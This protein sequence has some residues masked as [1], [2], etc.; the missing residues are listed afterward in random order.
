MLQLARGWLHHLTA[1]ETALQ[2]SGTHNS[3]WRR[4]L[5]REGQTD[6]PIVKGRFLVELS[7]PVPAGWPEPLL[8]ECVVAWRPSATQQQPIKKSTCCYSRHPFNRPEHHHKRQSQWRRQVTTATV[9]QL[10]R[11]TPQTVMSRVR[12]K[13]STMPRPEDLLATL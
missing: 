4:Y 8:C 2:A 3:V 7:P 12:R 10:D 11:K 5:L 13:V 6:G 9:A 1:V